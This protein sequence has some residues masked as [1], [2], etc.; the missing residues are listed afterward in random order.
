MNFCG[1]V[2]HV[3]NKIQGYAL[4]LIK[5]LEILVA[6][7]GHFIQ[8][9]PW[10]SVVLLFGFSLLTVPWIRFAAKNIAISIGIKKIT[11]SEVEIEFGE[12][13]RQVLVQSIDESLH[14]IS[15][16]R[17]KIDSK[18]KKLVQAEGLESAFEDAVKKILKKVCNNEFGDD[19]LRAT[20]HI[21]D[22]IF[23]ELLYQVTNYFPVGKGAYRRFSLRRGII[24]RVWRSGH[25]ASAGYLT[26]R[27]KLTAKRTEQQ[28][29]HRICLA[30]GITTQEALEFRTKP[31]YCC[32]PIFVNHRLVGLF[33][34]DS[35]KFN[36]GWNE[37]LP[38][39]RQIKKLNDLEIFC[40]K[41]IEEAGVS[42]ILENIER[43]MAKFAPRTQLDV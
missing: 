22:Y 27:T 38:K 30:W 1:V 5:Y 40:Q 6:W 43:E 12:Y 26:D 35:K 19:S 4:I 37:K 23:A 39:S 21:Q 24:G 11:F 31:S 25:P 16:Y 13:D 17:K 20:L 32:V 41:A 42:A 2:G 33:Y 9:N 8:S 29:I 14:L 18:I 36:F 3:W 7:I 28:N 15:I 10:P 34:M